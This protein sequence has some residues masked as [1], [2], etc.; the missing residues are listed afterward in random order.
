MFVG[1]CAPSQIALDNF[2]INSDQ[3]FYERSEVPRYY[4]FY[5]SHTVLDTVIGH[6]IQEAAAQLC[7]RQDSFTIEELQAAFDQL[8]GVLR[9]VCKC[10]HGTRDE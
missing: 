1:S 2:P 7:S 4:R 8:Q 5:Q 9:L 6:A 3:S 10:W